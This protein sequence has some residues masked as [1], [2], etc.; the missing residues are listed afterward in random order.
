[1]KTYSIFAVISGPE[2]LDRRPF[3]LGGRGITHISTDPSGPDFGRALVKDPYFDVSSRTIHVINIKSIFK[4]KSPIFSQS[5][6]KVFSVF[7]LLF[8]LFASISGASA[9]LSV[10]P[11]APTSVNIC[12]SNGFVVYIN[13][14]GTT[15]E[16][17]ILLNV[18]IP[19]GFSYDGNSNITFP[20]GSSN[21]GP[22]IAGLYLEWN[23]T[24]IMTTETGVVIN[25]VLPNPLGSDGSNERVELYNAGSTSVNVSGW[26]IN[27]TINNSRDI[28]SYIES[29]SV[30]MAPG[31]FLVVSMWRLDNPGDTVFLFNGTGV[32]KDS[33]TY[34]TSVE[35]KSWACM[36]DGSELWNWRSSTLG[37][38]NGDLAAGERIKV[39]FN[40]T[41]ACGT[42]SGGRIRADVFYLGGSAYK[43]SSSMLVKQG[44]L[45][46]TKTPTV[47]EAGVGDVV[48]WMITVENTGLGPAYNVRVN[49]TLSSGLNL[50]SIDSPGGGMNWT[51]DVIDP[52]DEKTVNI[53]VNVT[54]CQNLF[55]EVNA[56]WGCDGTP[57]QEVYAKAS[58]KFVPRDPDLEYTVSPMVVPYCGN[59]TVYVNV[60]NEGEG[61]I[62]NL[63][64]IFSGISADYAVSNV[65]GATYYPGNETFYIG[66]V[67]SGEWNNFTFDFGMAYGGC[68]VKGAAGTIT[69]YPHHHDDCGNPWYPPVSLESYSMD[70]ATIPSLSISKAADKSVAY[71]GEDVNYTLNV[72]YTAGSCGANTTRTIV[73]QYPGNFT[74]IDS[75]GGTEDATNHTITW[76]DQLLEDGVAWSRTIRLS[77]AV[78]TAACDC[79]KSVTNLLN[80]SEGVDCCGCN[81]SGTSS[82]EVI[83]ECINETILASSSKSASPTPQENCR[84]VTYTTTYTFGDNA[85]SLNW[86]DVNFTELGGNGQTFPDGGNS[87]KATFTVNGTCST[88]QTI[89]IASPTN[90]GFLNGACGPLGAAPSLQSHTPSESPRSGR[91][92]TGRYSASRGTARDAPATPASTSRLPSP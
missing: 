8:V 10:N 85:S 56:S 37:S 67:S 2:H 41:T 87:G 84:N 70:S 31:S 36:P 74:L 64:L 29:G 9:A 44:F 27:D 18:T 5:I 78:D 39:E 15:S 33:V 45:K 76:T 89:T 34:D 79:G 91:V 49:D 46:L 28:E 86:T 52:G 77:A 35:G 75:A 69:I 12:D 88:N 22:Q 81:I 14:T 47:V 58:V 4:Y 42:P 54:S 43:S 65:S 59:I 68:G 25:E 16:N 21:D 11:I 24:E 57:C 55:N 7:L 61:G 17:D 66:R 23:L 1:M 32:Q 62:T 73:D 40:L 92:P 30:E 13:N 20:N 50:L 80:V 3:G 90:L 63:E 83:I 6:A 19:S 53:S 38:T 60:S 71:L 26:Y 48:N 72:T 51:Y 82:A